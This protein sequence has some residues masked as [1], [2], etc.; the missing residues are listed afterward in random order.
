MFFFKGWS[1]CIYVSWR[2]FFNLKVLENNVEILVFFLMFFFKIVLEV[3]IIKILLICM[4]NV[5]EELKIVFLMF[6]FLNERLVWEMFLIEFNWK[7]FGE[8]LVINVKW[9]VELFIVFLYNSI[10]LVGFM[11]LKIDFLVLKNFEK[12]FFF[13][14]LRSVFFLKFWVVIF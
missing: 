12:G 13:N 6:F 2:L 10:F 7:S 11:N 5:M 3:E 1:L 4:L 14:W 8:I 9:F